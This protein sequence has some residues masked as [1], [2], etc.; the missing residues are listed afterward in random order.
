MTSTPISDS[1]YRARFKVDPDSPNDDLH[2][3][4]L[5][6]AL[7]IRKFEIDLYWKRATYFWAFIATALTGFI[8]I[9][10]SPSTNKADLSVLLSNLGIAFSFAWLCVNRGSKQW[11]ENWENHV[12]MLEDKVQGPLYKVVLSRRKPKGMKEWAL[13]LLTGPSPISVSKVNQLIGLYITA[14]WVG[15]LFYSLPSF[16]KTLPINWYY[17][18]IT[19]MTIVLCVLFATVGRTWGGG[20]SHRAVIRSTSIANDA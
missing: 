1:E 20:H 18:G 3:R 16:A 19:V 10:A 15:L 17:V 5:E 7:D 11:Q 8:I 14:L 2:A 6:R 9:Q 12:D 4:A 13:H